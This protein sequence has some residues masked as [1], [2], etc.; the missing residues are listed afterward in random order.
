MNT[1]PYT[2]GGDQLNLKDLRRASA[3]Q[4]R[5]GPPAKKGDFS[6]EGKVISEAVWEAL[7][8]CWK[9][10]PEERP[11]AV[12]LADRLEAIQSPFKAEAICGLKVGMERLELGLAV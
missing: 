4:R 12:Q 3:R 10:F 7:Q 8:D 1:F 11:S 6:F 9:A 2:A 5:G